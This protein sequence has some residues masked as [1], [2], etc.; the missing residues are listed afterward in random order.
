MPRPLLWRRFV[1]A[2]R[3]LPRPMLLHDALPAMSKTSTALPGPAESPP[4]PPR[5]DMWG[6]VE[7]TV[8][9]VQDAYFTQLD[10]NGH[11]H[12][13]DDLERFAALGL[14]AIRYPVL[15][16]AIAPEGIAAA[17]WSWPD[18]RL[19]KLNELGVAPIVGLAAARAT[20]ACSIPASRTAWRDSRRRPRRA[21]RGSSTGRPS[22]SH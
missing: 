7:C 4:N 18:R 21:I 17:D 15:W 20:R 5:I 11:H 19:A 16:E 12:R 13:D 8:N 1:E 6:G 9:R 22:T 2:A 3:E 10:R 14:R